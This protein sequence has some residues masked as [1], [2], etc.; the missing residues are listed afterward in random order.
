MSAKVSSSENSRHR[1][2]LPPTWT[3]GTMKMLG[4]PTWKKGSWSAAEWP[5]WM[6]HD[7]MVL[8]LF[9][10]MLPWVRIAPLGSP[11]VPPV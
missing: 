7:T 11:V 10:V 9:Q 8:T 4:P 5:A 2:V 1:I 3:S 6:P